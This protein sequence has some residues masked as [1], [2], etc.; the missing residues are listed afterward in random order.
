MAWTCGGG[1]G[2]QSFDI[3]LHN[4]NYSIMNGFIP[5]A[6]RVPMERL[7]TGRKNF[8][9]ELEVDLADNIPTG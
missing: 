9:G 7:P 6:L 2:I 3:Q 5:I 8:G 1:T 4:A